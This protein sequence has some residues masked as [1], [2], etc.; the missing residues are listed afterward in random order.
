MYL[1]Q[2]NI[3]DFILSKDIK[4]LKYLDLNL[5]FMKNKINIINFYGNK[6]FIDEN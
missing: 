1:Y 3:E 6:D 2:L 4:A 5:I